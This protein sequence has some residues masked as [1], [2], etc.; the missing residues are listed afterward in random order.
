MPRRCQT[1]STAPRTGAPAARLRPG[2]R[3]GRCRAECSQRHRVHQCQGHA[4]RRVEQRDHALN[5]RQAVACGVVREIGIH[6]RCK[7]RAIERQHA[8][9]DVKAAV[10]RVHPENARGRRLAERVLTKCILYCRDTSLRRE[11]SLDVAAREKQCAGVRV[12][13][14]HAALRFK[15]RPAEHGLRDEGDS[16]PP[17]H[18]PCPG[19]PGTSQ[20]LGEMPWDIPGVCHGPM[21]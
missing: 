19:Q 20:N 18:Y 8:C 17:R 12:F 10:L 14:W 6:F 5:G 16:I 7:V 1:L 13:V 15:P 21:P 2:H 9:L 3:R 4:T 11:K